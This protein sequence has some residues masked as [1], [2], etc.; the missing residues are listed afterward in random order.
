VAVFW[1]RRPE[2]AQVEAM[3]IDLEAALVSCL[4]DTAPGA[5][6]HLTQ[7]EHFLCAA[8]TGRE[9]ALHM[10]DNAFYLAVL[11]ANKARLV[12]REWIETSLQVLRYN[13]RAW[14]DAQRIVGPQGEAPCTFPLRLL[15]LSLHRDQDDSE[16]NPNF[17]RELLRTAFTGLLPPH[18]LM[19]AATQ[20]FGI[21]IRSKQDDKPQ[22]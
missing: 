1:L 18:A 17:L 10:P 4:D 22:K 14:F 7:M 2:K 13:L 20:R 9:A 21:L 8:E 11:S 3:E 15:V 12:V 19:E 16:A 5:A 6:A